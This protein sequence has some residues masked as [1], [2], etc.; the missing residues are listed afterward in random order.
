MSLTEIYISIW[1]LS[2]LFFTT[3]T[4]MSLYKADGLLVTTI[5]TSMMSVIFVISLFTTVFLI[6]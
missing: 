3:T 5:F 6:T 4:G 1:F 2:L